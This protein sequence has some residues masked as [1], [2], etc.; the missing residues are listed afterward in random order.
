MLILAAILTSTANFMLRTD[1]KFVP[2]NRS[3]LIG[4]GGPGLG[5]FGCLGECTSEI[6][7]SSGGYSY[8][9]GYLHG[10]GIPCENANGDIP[11]GQGTGKYGAVSLWDISKVQNLAS[12]ECC[13]IFL[14][15]C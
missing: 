5:L 2:T 13:T 14:F 15:L 6:K 9:D 12:G 10:T 3:I 1:A 11:S 8:C 4:D 7:I